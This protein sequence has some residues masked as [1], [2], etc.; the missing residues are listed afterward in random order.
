M[1]NN[2][3]TVEAFV[4]RIAQILHP[5]V[6]ECRPDRA[7]KF[8]Q[9]IGIYIP[10]TQL[11]AILD[12]IGPIG[13]KADLLIEAACAIIDDVRDG[14]YTDVL[15]DGKK[16]VSLV[17]ELIKAVNK[18]KDT[19]KVLNVITPAE[20]DQ[21]LQRIFNRLMVRYMERIPG[22]VEMMKLLDVIRIFPQNQDGSNPNLPPY[23]LY[24]INFGVIGD[25]IG[26]SKG[27]FRK[28]YK[29]GDADFDAKRLFARLEELLLA[30]DMPAFYDDA[31]PEAV[32]GLSVASAT[33]DKR[34]GTPGIKVDLSWPAPSFVHEWGSS[35]WKNRFE[36][37]MAMPMSAAV[38]I[39]PGGKIEIMPPVASPAINGSIKYTLT[40]KKAAPFVLFAVPGGSRLQLDEIEVVL[41]AALNWKP[42]T[43]K[44]DGQFAFEASLKGCKIIIHA[45]NADSFLQSLLPA[46]HAEID[47][48][49]KIGWSAQTGFYIAGSSALEINLPVKKTIG[50]VAIEGLSVSLKPNDKTLPLLVGANITGQLGPITI[51]I[52]DIGASATLDFKKA[53]S[54]G[55]AQ[56]DVGF[57]PP[58]GVGLQID[59]GMI[60]GGGFLQL[61]VEKGEYV[62][63]MDLSVNNTIQVAA[64]GI[65]NTKLP[66]GEKGFSLL[67]IISAAFQPGIALGMGFFLGGLG[68]MLG[69]HRTIHVPALLEG[70]ANNSISN[71]LFP[72]NIVKNINTLLPQVKT[73][74][75]VQKDQFFVGLM[76]R[77]TWGVPTLL[78]IDFG[79]AVEFPS[80]VRMVILGV[81][82]VALPSEDKALLKL[83]VNFAGAIDFDR[84][85]LAFD[86]A[87]VNSKLLSFALEGQ[88]A[89]RLSWGN[90]KAF[91]L[92]AGGFHPAFKPPAE[93]KVPSL[94]RITLTVYQKNPY[95][96]LSSYFAITS[97]TVQLG[98]KIDFKYNISKF[99]IVGFM[100][101][102]VLFQFSPFYFESRIAAGLA[103]K[104]GKS[105]IMSLSLDFLLSGP[106]PWN[107]RGTAKFSILFISVKVKFNVTWEEAKKVMPPSIAVMP[108]LVA[109]LELPSNWTAEAPAARPSL[110]TIG[111]LNT[112]PGE[113]ILQ[114]YGTLKI[115]QTVLPLNV[116]ISQFG[117]GIPSDVKQ[118]K[119]TDLSIGN[120]SI[121]MDT[122]ND[123]FAPANFRKMSDADKLKA[124]SFS[125][126][127]SGVKFTDTSSGLNANYACNHDSNLNIT[128]SDND[129]P[130]SPQSYAISQ[131]THRSM[132]KGGAIGKSPLSALYSQQQLENSV[133][134]VKEE[135]FV[136]MNNN[137]RAA[138][139]SAAFQGGSRI[140]AEDALATLLTA[141]PGLKGLVSVVPAY[142]LT[143]LN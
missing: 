103:V 35:A 134:T 34:N 111:K 119:I 36:L 19:I 38:S 53:G 3:G 108:A 105:T 68:G 73:L 6:Y 52:Q 117:N 113:I 24:E 99:S 79:I 67:I 61:D 29:W 141:N 132:T 48:D 74:F 66:G 126:E 49:L 28:L 62:G 60:K 63:A 142:T 77:I 101:F 17:E 80:P 5:L 109:A 72:T 39:V 45:A 14:Q 11:N 98:A 112:A 27:Q 128:V 129:A 86:A 100:S 115:S 20:A 58:K 26:D 57:K 78:R 65:I 124:A 47:F 9:E 88:M 71:I 32:L 59:A 139:T 87:L 51:S 55:F 85:Y 91:L 43:G 122:V 96:V 131:N 140:Q 130:A 127:T 89:L 12:T 1:G 135:T 70:A 114:P 136:L 64:I 30:F 44:A 18:L 93:L 138:Y 97:N 133:A 107:A 76:A 75:P 94:K 37:G 95:L 121:S 81:L 7:G 110:V 33:V 41:G 8:L 21:L 10:V 13:S 22:M 50:P 104:C 123:L 31:L 137:S 84:K 82:K 25:W 4:V 46:L 42:E 102:D 83:Q 15:D 120:K 118:V 56:I 40:G 116:V 106:A 125:M 2:T 143:Q 54:L 92:S 16:A 23:S 69:I 90:N